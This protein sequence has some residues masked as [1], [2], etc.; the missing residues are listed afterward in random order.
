MG[1]PRHLVG[2]AASRPAWP[3]ALGLWTGLVFAAWLGAPFAAAGTARWPAGWLHL[4]SLAAGLS[5]HQAWVARHNPGL[6]AA[7]RRPGPGTKGW[8]L[9]WNALFWPLLA[10]V[11]LVAGLEFRA[12]G[13][14]LPPLAWGAGLLVLA[15]GLGLSAW[16][17]AVNPFFEGTVRIQR[18]RGQRVVE[19]GP[20]RRVRHPGY[21]GLAL[22]AVASPL[23]LRSAAAWWPALAVVA[24]L[25]LRTALEDGVLRRELVGY[26]AYCGR[27]RW[28]WVPGVW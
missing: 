20:Y 9:A 16:A 1:G 18:E 11:A 23:L 12:G 8:D 4:A 24:W 10:S 17:A 15:A 14:A 19:R 2:T 27:T 26:R 6:R 3:G 22:V 7:R 28:R 5:A 21:A 13:A 25:A